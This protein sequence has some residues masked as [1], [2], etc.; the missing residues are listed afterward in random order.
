MVNVRNEWRMFATPFLVKKLILWSKGLSQ[1]LLSG[2][3]YFVY[4]AVLATQ[5]IEA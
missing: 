5:S 4:K 1:L 3:T 2:L